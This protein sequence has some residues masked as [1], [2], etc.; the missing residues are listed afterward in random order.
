MDYLVYVEYNA[1]NLQ[2]FLWY[3]DYVRRFNA[4]PETEKV[5]SKEWIPDAKETPDLKKD[6]ENNEKKRPKRETSISNIGYAAKDAVMI[7]EEELPFSPLS[8]PM[9]PTLPTK[10]LS[11]AGTATPSLS[12]SAAPSDAEVAAQAGLKWQPCM[13]SSGHFE[14]QYINTNGNSHNPAIARGN[15]PHDAPLHCI[16]RSK[17]TKPLTQRPITLSSRSTTHYPSLRSPPSCDHRRSCFTWTITPKFCPLVHM[18]RQQAP[19]ILCSNHGCPPHRIRI[20]N[21]SRPY[22]IRC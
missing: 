22:V 6:A 13:S 21:R 9:S 1:E 16:R 18:Q 14:E 17:R 3:K 8:P 5:L 19:G 12:G 4:L 15:Q 20:H 10:H 7:T 2:F 11:M